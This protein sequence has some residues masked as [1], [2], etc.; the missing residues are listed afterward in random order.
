MT[1]RHF[2]DP[3]LFQKS[4]QTFLLANE[5]ENILPLGILNNVICG[6]YREREP[7]LALV[8][9]G[10]KPALIALCTPPH[11]VLISYQKPSPPDEIL[12]LVLK[13]LMDFLGEDF[14]GISGNKMLAARLKEIWEEMT[15]R[16]AKKYMAMRIYKLEEV[17]PLPDMAGSIRPVEKK[18]RRL[19]M[20]W[21][22]GFFKEAAHESLDP[23]RARKQFE[24]YLKAD[25]KLRGLMIWEK[26]GVPVSMAGYAGP[27]PN[28]I[29]VGPVYT[30]PEKR[31]KGYASSLTA[32]LS[33]ELLNMG[34]KFCFLFT[35]L[36][37]PTSNHIYQQ[38][39]YN[40]VC[41]VDRFDFK[42]P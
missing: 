24:L 15:G 12:E 36:M 1:I 19:I 6:D 32:R 5:A 17:I 23:T 9:E 37:N 42:K 13:D 27:T 11:P 3:V 14:M 25:P 40:P 16:K 21:L 38:I 26:K 28:G 33:Q 34:F 39:G 29:R 7:Y 35:D 8:E 20:D 22:N 10:G 41:D 31:N 4:T 30:P 18:D 2:D